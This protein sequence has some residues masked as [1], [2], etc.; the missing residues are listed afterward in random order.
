MGREDLRWRWWRRVPAIKGQWLLAQ[1]SWCGGVQ[2][3][4]EVEANRS[5]FAIN[6]LWRAPNCGD[7]REGSRESLWPEV[8]ASFWG[9]GILLSTPV[10]LPRPCLHCRCILSKMQSLGAI[11]NAKHLILRRS[12]GEKAAWELLWKLCPGSL[13]AASLIR[14]WPEKVICLRHPKRWLVCLEI[15][16][17]FNA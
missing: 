4:S 9:E 15:A 5:S 3:Q 13:V 17:I 7:V 14:F 11:R 10:L 1:Q 2:R 12:W 6:Q 8:A 16:V